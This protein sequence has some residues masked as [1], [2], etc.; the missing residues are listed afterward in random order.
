MIDIPNFE[1]ALDIVCAVIADDCGRWRNI[2]PDYSGTTR[3][4]IESVTGWS[5][6]TVHRL[7]SHLE[8]CGHVK[9]KWTHQH[10]SYWEGHFSLSYAENREDGQK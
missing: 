2:F 6:S 3:R 8:K 10:Q 1:D 9:A 7:V 5:Y 4:E